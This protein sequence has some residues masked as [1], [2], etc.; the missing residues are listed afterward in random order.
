M[1]ATAAL[2]PEPDPGGTPRAI[3]AALLPE[4]VGD[5]DRAWRAALAEAAETLDLTGV[6]KTLENWRRIARMTQAD[7]EAHRRMLRQAEHTLRTGELPA[8]S[9]P[10]DEVKALIRERLGL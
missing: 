10:I 4:E 8:G 9:V 2:G 5:F 6:Y 7:P 3:R 1:S